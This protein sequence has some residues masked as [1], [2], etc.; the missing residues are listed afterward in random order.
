MKPTHLVLFD[1]DG[2]L[3]STKRRGW[4]PPFCDALEEVLMDEVKFMEDSIQ[5]VAKIR[6]NAYKYRPGGKTD[7][8][9]IFELLEGM[10]VSEAEIH[11]MLPAFRE[12]YLE[13]LRKVI[14]TQEDAELKPGIK[15]LLEA[16]S[17]RK[18]AVLS[19]LT[20]N[21]EEGARIKLDT[22]ELERY[23]TFEA[24]A[25]GDYAKERKMLPGRAVEAA[26]KHTGRHFT[27]KE[28]V[29]IGDTPNDVRCGKHLN[30]R[31]IA[32]ATSNYSLE[33]LKAEGPDYVF[34]DLT[35]TQ[36]VISAIL[37]PVLKNS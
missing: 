7:T 14:R 37:E 5:E 16:L 4:E 23:F 20:G 10:N 25:F 22:H 1:I 31:T 30:V 11:R 36:K 19:L 2:T 17:Q 9:I 28:V 8:Q 34:S 15:E 32:V 29:I 13:R 27:G 35:D 12:K 3:L 18:E 6:L 26:K 33:D 24:G 21:F